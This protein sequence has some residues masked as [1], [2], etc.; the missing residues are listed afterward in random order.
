[1]GKE[2][3]VKSNLSPG[4]KFG[5]ITFFTHPYIF[6]RSSSKDRLIA[7]ANGITDE[8]FEGYYFKA[9]PNEKISVTISH[10]N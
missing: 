8:V 7:K 3:V 4:A 5:Q 1:M 9:K 2:S 6:K 10:G